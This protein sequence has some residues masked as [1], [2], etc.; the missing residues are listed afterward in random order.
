MNVCTITDEEFVRIINSVCENEVGG[1]G[2]FTPI[3]TLEDNVVEAGLDSL[4]VMMV[5]VWIT[6]GFG[7]SDEDAENA[8]KAEVITG[9]DIVNFIK[10]YQTKGYTLEEVRATFQRD[11]V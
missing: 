11:N 10:K 6:E 5:Y 2:G 3:A 1:F 8:V 4:G 9:H 7:I